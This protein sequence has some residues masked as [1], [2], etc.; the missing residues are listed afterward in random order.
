MELPSPP[1]PLWHCAPQA[2]LQ[3]ILLGEFSLGYGL[4]SKFPSRK[5]LCGLTFHSRMLLLFPKGCSLG[6]VQLP[7]DPL[8]PVIAHLSPAQIPN[9]VVLQVYS[10]LPSCGLS[11]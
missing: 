10:A 1:N 9:S 8:S 2:A 4:R 11:D 3:A 6:A 5:L 7:P